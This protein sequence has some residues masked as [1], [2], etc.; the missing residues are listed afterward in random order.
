MSP[1]WDLFISSLCITMISFAIIIGLTQTVKI[2]INTYIGLIVAEGLGNIIQLYLNSKISIFKDLGVEFNEYTLIII[3]IS[4]FIGIIVSLTI[5][6]IFDI[7]VAP[8]NSKTVKYVL[9]C[10]YGFLLALMIIS[11]ILLYAS[12]TSLF[13]PTQ[14]TVSYIRESLINQSEFIKNIVRWANV[15]LSIPFLLILFN[16]IKTK[17]E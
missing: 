16:G 15:W 4:I 5:L 11:V 13:F 12:G 17:K 1:T 7:I 8:P 10:I 9:T 2:I 6:P 3:K 14:S